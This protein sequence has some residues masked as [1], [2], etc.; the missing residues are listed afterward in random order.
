MTHLEFGIVLY[1]KYNMTKPLNPIIVFW[2][3]DKPKRL[4][5]L[6]ELSVLGKEQF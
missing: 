4:K 5:G 1:I 2:A 3:I 6:R